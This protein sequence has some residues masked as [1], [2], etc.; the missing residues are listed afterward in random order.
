[1]NRSE[2]NKHKLKKEINGMNMREKILFEYFITH[3]K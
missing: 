3:I 1:M 2:S